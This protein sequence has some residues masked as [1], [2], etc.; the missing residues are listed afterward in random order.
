MKKLRKE[1]CSRLNSSTPTRG[2]S[3]GAVGSKPGEKSKRNLELLR[4]MK[5]LRMSL[6]T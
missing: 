4:D 1:A 5:A 3:A 2:R 6:Q